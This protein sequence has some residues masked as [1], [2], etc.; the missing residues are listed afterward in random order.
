[1]PLKCIK[2]WMSST[3][4]VLIYPD[5]NQDTTLDEKEISWTAVL[6]H[7]RANLVK[8][9]QLRAVTA[10]QMVDGEVERMAVY[11]QFLTKEPGSD[12]INFIAFGLLLQWDTGKITVL[13]QQCIRRRFHLSVWK[14]TKGM[15]SQKSNNINYTVIK[16]YNVISLL[17]CLDNIWEKIA[18]NILVDLGEVHLFLY[19]RE[20]W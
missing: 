19:E 10:L 8:P 1:M 13:I 4:L 11:D 9:F 5:R 15:I 6:W 16:S 18:A 3:T 7:P 20:I 2:L 17:T 12:C 14:I